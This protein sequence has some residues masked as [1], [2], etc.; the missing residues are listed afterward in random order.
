MNDRYETKDKHL[1]VSQ[2]WVKDYI[3]KN[4]LYMIDSSFNVLKDGFFA[5]TEE[6]YIVKVTANSI[7]KNQSNPIFSN[8]NPYTIYNIKRYLFLN[9]IDT[10]LLS[11]S[12]VNN[13]T[14]LEWQCV[15][16]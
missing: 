10:V 11:D 8:L 13:H 3:L 16:E 14:N 12:Y 5:F 4:N 6:G 2:Q 7:Y 1:T 15:W 9:N